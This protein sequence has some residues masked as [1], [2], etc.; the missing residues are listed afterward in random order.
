MSPKSGWSEHLMAQIN[1]Y[2]LQMGL[3][4]VQEVSILSRLPANFD[5]GCLMSK[6]KE[7][8]FA[9]IS[10]MGALIPITIC[11]ERCY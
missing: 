5:P 4:D 3:P 6:N 10:G 8:H 7:P 1:F 11:Q 2:K 9:G